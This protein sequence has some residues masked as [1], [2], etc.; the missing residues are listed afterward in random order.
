MSKRKRVQPESVKA[1]SEV[2]ESA[3]AY[4]QRLD[5]AREYAKKWAGSGPALEEVRFRQLQELDDNMARKMMLDLFDMWCP[6]IRED[7]GDGMV[8]QQRIFA[9]LRR[10]ESEE[11]TGK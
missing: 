11:N 3:G 10:R 9:K 5:G 4:S 1:G 2:S 7:L 8:E 6:G